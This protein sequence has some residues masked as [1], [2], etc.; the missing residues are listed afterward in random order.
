METFSKSVDTE[1]KHI[2]ILLN[3]KPVDVIDICEDNEEINDD[4]TIDIIDEI[5]DE[6]IEE[7]TDEAINEITE[8]IVDKNNEV[9]Q[10]KIHIDIYGVEEKIN[11]KAVII[12]IVKEKLLQEKMSDHYLDHY[13]K[14]RFSIFIELYQIHFKDM[15]GQT[16]FEYWKTNEFEQWNNNSINEVFHSKYSK[17]DNKTR[18]SIMTELSGKVIRVVDKKL[19]NFHD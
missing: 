7:V 11:D 9:I 4:D 1:N 15:E 6:V 19:F 18:K 13:H 10:N 14:K 2:H 12:D 3:N 5:I 17:S 8:E 16:L